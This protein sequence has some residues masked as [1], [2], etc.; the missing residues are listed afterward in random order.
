MNWI[1]F[2]KYLASGYLLYYGILI[3][4]DLL[5]PDRDSLSLEDG[6]LVEFPVESET[7]HINTG[8]GEAQVTSDSGLSP[9]GHPDGEDWKLYRENDNISTGGVSSMT[10]LFRLAQHEAIEVKKHLVY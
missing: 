9:T 1:E 2:V 5:R 7:T 3:A 8:K 4:L 6:D 10:E